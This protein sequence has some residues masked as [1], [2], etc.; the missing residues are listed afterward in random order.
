MNLGSGGTDISLGTV[1]SAMNGLYNWDKNAG[2]EDAARRNK[3]NVATALRSQWGYGDMAAREQL[4]SILEGKTVLREGEGAGEAETVLEDGTRVV[5]LN[6]YREGMGTAEQLLLGVTVQHEAHR[7]GVYT[8]DN[9]LETR[10]AARG[11]TEMAIRMMM[12]GETLAESEYLEKDIM[13]YIMAGGNRDAFNAYVDGNYDSS[14]D[15]WKLAKDANGNWGWE[16]DESYDFN[17]DLGDKEIR[18]IFS[19]LIRENKI[20]DIDRIREAGLFEIEEMPPLKN[21]I[22]NGIGTIAFSDMTEYYIGKLA[23]NLNLRGLSN[24][25]QPTFTNANNRYSPTYWYPLYESFVSGTAAL[26]E[27]GQVATDLAKDIDA[28]SS[29]P[30]SAQKKNDQISRLNSLLYTAQKD[31]VVINGKS[32][33]I[34]SGLHGEGTNETPY[35]PLT[36]TVF[37]TSLPGIRFITDDFYNQVK[38]NVTNI[39][40]YPLYGFARYPH[41]NAD[42]GNGQ[43]GVVS[44]VAGSISLG[45][46]KNFTYGLYGV[47]TSADGEMAFR[48]NHLDE[49][50]I[51]DYIQLYASGGTKL[52]MDS[53]GQYTLTGVQ[54]GVRFGT[55]GSTG[56]S[57]S[58]HVDWAISKKGSNL[59]SAELFNSLIYNRRDFDYEYDI[60]DEDRYMSGLSFNNFGNQ[61]IFSYMQ[62][63]KGN[64]DARLT[65]YD[66][67]LKQK[68][69]IGI[70]QYNEI[71][72]LLLYSF[73]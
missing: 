45:Y 41:A 69:K 66:E 71:L 35:L 42:L 17:F 15:F 64:D 31:G 57:G 9:N 34:A 32:Q 55:K 53:S 40:N 52:Q 1:F 36:G 60:S 58:A 18:E 23:G 38:N 65:Y 63:R 61:H 62:T 54:A 46:D 25:G 68:T 14:A 29:N 67:L 2:I 22:Q 5:Y 56:T 11:H 19:A 13:A 43:D 33:T 59:S 16:W 37:I 72:N 70:N 51:K 50:S 4:E 12:G 7:D 21:S 20:A 28:N 30:N 24:L 6:N 48:S 10:D 3:M 73:E 47:N 49:Q 26:A 39:A 27:A 8:R 44:S